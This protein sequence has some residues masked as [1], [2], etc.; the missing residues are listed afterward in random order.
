MF[1]LGIKKGRGASGSSRPT[2]GWCPCA[3][4]HRDQHNRGE[5]TFWAGLGIDDPLSFATRLFEVTGDEPP[6]AAFC[7]KGISYDQKNAQ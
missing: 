6:P 2:T 1:A 5:P 3:D 7:L 4:C